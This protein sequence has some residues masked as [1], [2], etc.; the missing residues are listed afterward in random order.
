MILLAYLLFFIYGLIVVMLL[1]PKTNIFFLNLTNNNIIV[2]PIVEEFWKSLVYII[3]LIFPFFYNRIG[4]LKKV[5]P[6]A[7]SYLRFT[8]RYIISLVFM[9][10]LAFGLIEGM[11]K[12]HSY[13]DKGDMALFTGAIILNIWIHTM[14]TEYP[15]LLSKSLKKK[16]IFFFP[17][18]IF[19]HLLH[20]YLIEYYWDNKIVTLI[21]A[22]VLSI[23][24]IPRFL[25]LIKSKIH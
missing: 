12:N 14:Y 18:A 24:F 17:V 11:I 20:N 19:L 2:P 7:D 25:L 3:P 9:V 1:A 13:Y 10:T 16:V 6:Y 5:M 15:I 22:I 4:F 8:N 21:L 23:I